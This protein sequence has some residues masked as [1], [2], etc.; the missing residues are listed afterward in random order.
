MI[1]GFVDELDKFLLNNGKCDSDERE[2]IIEYISK[3]F[4]VE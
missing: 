1:K 2:E 4:K 3:N